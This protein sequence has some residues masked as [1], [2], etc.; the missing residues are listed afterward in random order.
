MIELL[1]PVKEQGIKC[2]FLLLGKIPA[3]PCQHFNL[4]GVTVSAP[5]GSHVPEERTHYLTG[6]VISRVFLGESKYNQL[7]HV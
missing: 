2:P 6:S 7:L 4:A 5:A 3:F 1:S